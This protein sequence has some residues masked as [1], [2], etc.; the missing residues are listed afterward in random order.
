MPVL[1]QTWP[2]VPA[3]GTGCSTAWPRPILENA[4]P[5]RVEVD[6]RLSWDTNR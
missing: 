1:K 4:D 3:V 5:L 6:L 2:I